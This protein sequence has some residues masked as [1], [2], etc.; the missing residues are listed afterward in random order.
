MTETWA[1]ELQHP[2]AALFTDDLL[3]PCAPGIQGVIACVLAASVPAWRAARVEPIST[4][5]QD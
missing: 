1:W 4:L 2:A 5:R 3:K